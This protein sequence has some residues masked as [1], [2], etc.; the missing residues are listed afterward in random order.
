MSVRLWNFKDATFLPENRHAQRKLFLN[1]PAM[2]YCSSKSAE[3]ILSVNF[4]CQKLT[5]FFQ[6]KSFKNINL[7]DHFL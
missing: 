1:N 2:K 5:E 3:I 6:K 7:G 4:L